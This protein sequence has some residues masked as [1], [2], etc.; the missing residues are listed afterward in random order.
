MKPVL[1]ASDVSSTM[2]HAAAVGA[3][4][5]PVLVDADANDVQKLL[6]LE[7]TDVRVHGTKA[8]AA[9]IVALLD[10]TLGM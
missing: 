2:V 8:S 7:G 1:A 4:A 6:D 9:V 10:L 3:I 5:Q